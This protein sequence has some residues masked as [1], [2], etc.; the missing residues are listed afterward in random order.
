M[1]SY[2]GLGQSDLAEQERKLYLRF[3]ADEAAQAITGPY[4]RLNPEDNRE[5]QAIHEH[6]GASLSKANATA[7]RE[8]A[9]RKTKPAQE[10]H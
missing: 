8:S 4:R 6:E 2:Q 10:G 7:Q 1:L 5:R 9:Q 3:K